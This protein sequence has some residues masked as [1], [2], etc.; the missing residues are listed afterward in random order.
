MQYPGAILKLASW[1][2]REK[3]DVIQ[4]HLYDASFVGLIAGQL[5]RT[6][7]IVFTG[8]H[9]QEIITYSQNFNRKLPLWLDRL[10]SGFLSNYIIAPSEQ[11]KQSFVLSH[12]IPESKVAVIPH[13]FDFANWHSTN[14]TARERIRAELGVNGKV[15]FGAVGR[16]YW[17]KDYSNLIRAFAKFS[18]KATDAVLLIVGAGDQTELRSVSEELQI[19][20]RVIFTGPRQDV[21]DLYAAMDVFVH[22]SLAESFGL[23][24]AEAMAMNKPV[25]ST[26]VGIARQTVIDEVNGFVIPPGDNQAL[27][28]AF[29]KMAQNRARWSE[30]GNAGQ[31]QIRAY[32]AQKM[33]ADYEEHYIKWLSL[34]RNSDN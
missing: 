8:H 27:I 2:R 15:V 29:E 24:I 5:A 26:N 21:M 31:R 33:V 3:V 14:E 7:L 12:K 6:P 22:S 28:N 34:V 16:I 11:M 18:E 30:M 10:N 4:T 19:S 9:S 32:T 13:G 25:I 23:V 20:D 17:I 1:L